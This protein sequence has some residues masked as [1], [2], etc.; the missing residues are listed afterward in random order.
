VTFSPVRI[1]TG[2]ASHFHN[3]A[4]AADKMSGAL[5]EGLSLIRVA[6][7]TCFLDSKAGQHFVWILDI[8]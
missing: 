1:M 2:D 5:V 7:E 6:A 8:Y 4:L 3:P